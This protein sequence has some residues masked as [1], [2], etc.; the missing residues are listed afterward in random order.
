MITAN[1][2]QTD[3]RADVSTCRIAESLK[4][5]I[6]GLPGNQFV[7]AWECIDEIAAA[8]N[9]AGPAALLALAYIQATHG[10]PR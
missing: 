8:M 2:I 5:R 7:Q 3:S 9:K 1:H 4:Q 10:A 6:E